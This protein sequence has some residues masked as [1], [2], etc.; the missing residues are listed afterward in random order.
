MT[1]TLPPLPYDR[2]ALEPLISQSTVDYHY[3]KHHQT[4]VNNLNRLVAGTEYEGQELETIVRHSSGG[5]FNNAAQVWN[6]TFYWNSMRPG[7]GGEPDAA[8]KTRII[9]DFGSMS[10]F[11]DEFTAA[12][13]GQFGSGWAW[14]VQAPN[15]RLAITTTT[16]AQ[17]PLTTVDKPLLT[18]DV[19]EHAY[20]LDRQ[21]D[22]AAYVEAWWQLVNWDFASRNA[23]FKQQATFA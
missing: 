13:I 23:G 19:W 4:Y 10:V 16:N 1:I 7:G 3:G 22:R 15:G 18:C 14:L 5:L 6:H 17:T 8:L 2:D 11:R 20:Y 21:N 9:D 12:A